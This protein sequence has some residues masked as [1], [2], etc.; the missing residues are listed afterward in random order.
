MTESTDTHTSMCIKLSTY[1]HMYI[2]VHTYVHMNTYT[3]HQTNSIK[4]LKRKQRVNWTENCNTRT[5][6]SENR[7]QRMRVYVCVCLRAQ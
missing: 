7:Q 1:I 6:I 3:R 5:L 4:N 2:L